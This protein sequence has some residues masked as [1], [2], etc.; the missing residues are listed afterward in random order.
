MQKIINKKSAFWIISLICITIWSVI[1]PKDLFTWFLESV[2]V[3]MGAVILIYSYRNFPLTPLLYYLL[4]MHAVILLIGAH[5][6]YAEVPLFDHIAQMFGHTRN[7]YDNVGHFVQGFVPAMIA[8]EILLRMTP[9]KQGKILKIIIISVAL[10][11]S[12]TYELIE[13]AVAE[14]TG[15]SAEAF[16]GT[17]GDVWDTQ[18]DMAFALTGAIFALLTLTKLHNKQLENTK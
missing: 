5:Y 4:F 6:T 9:I 14:M 15:E 8:R 7:N 1:E 17:Q 2:P 3:F 13:W 12:A 10:A 11:I 18:K 16:L